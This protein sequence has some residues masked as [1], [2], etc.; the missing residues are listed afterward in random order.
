MSNY[1]VHDGYTIINVIV[2]ENK[3]IAEDLTG[4]SAIEIT[5]NY[6]GI[7][8]TLEENGWR[9]PSPYPSWIWDGISWNAPVP[10][11]DDNKSYIWNEE[12]ILWDLVVVE[13]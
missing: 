1:A 13:E 12:N 2:A 9:P 11:P 6:L 10:Y 7:G 3:K 5:D 4:L 8:W